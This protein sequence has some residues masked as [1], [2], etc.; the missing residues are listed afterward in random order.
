MSHGIGVGS[1]FGA[2]VGLQDAQAVFGGNGLAIPRAWRFLALQGIGYGFG[3][4]LW[5]AVGSP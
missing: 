4:E 3:S 2:E 5:R 1:S